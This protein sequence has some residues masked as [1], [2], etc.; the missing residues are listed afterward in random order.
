[1]NNPV[2]PALRLSGAHIESMRTLITSLNYARWWSCQTAAQALLPPTAPSGCMLTIALYRYNELS[3]ALRV[4]YN[5]L[6][7]FCSCL[8]LWHVV[9][10]VVHTIIVV[11]CTRSVRIWNTPSVLF[12]CNVLKRGF[13]FSSLFNNG[14]FLFIHIR[15]NKALMQSLERHLAKGS[16]PRSSGQMRKSQS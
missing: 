7:S 16:G 11:H 2:S 5:I 12:I 1:M 3:I 14:A 4:L 13:E 9:K 6:Y 8:C 10:S 15:E